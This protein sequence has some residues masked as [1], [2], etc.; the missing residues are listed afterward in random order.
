MSQSTKQRFHQEIRTVDLPSIVNK[1]GEDHQSLL[2]CQQMIDAALNR[3]RLYPNQEGKPCEYEPLLTN[4]FRKVKVFSSNKN[5]AGEKP[6]LRIIYRFNSND[7]A[8]EILAIGFRIKARPRPPEDPYSRAE[9]RDL[10]F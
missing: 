7:D 2:V 6:D 3:I 1:F 5:L 10:L 9:I 4:G 8:V